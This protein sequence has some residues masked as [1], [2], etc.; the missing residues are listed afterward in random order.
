MIPLIWLPGYSPAWGKPREKLKE[1][2]KE[3]K[4]LFYAGQFCMAKD[5][6][7]HIRLCHTDH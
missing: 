2:K 5:S 4:L 1:T 3:Y 7:A 6:T